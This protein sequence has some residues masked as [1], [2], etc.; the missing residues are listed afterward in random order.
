MATSSLFVKKGLAQIKEIED[1][2]PHILGDRDRLIQVV[3]NLISNA[4]KFTDEGSVTCCARQIK[5]ELVISII[6]TGGYVSNSDDVFEEEIRKQV[7][8]AIDEADVVIFLVDVL[9]GI[10][11]LDQ[12][13][14]GML[15]KINKPVLLVVNK[16]DNL[17]QLLN[18]L[19][20]FSI[21]ALSSSS[22]LYL[23]QITTKSA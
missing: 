10:T 12:T 16:V 21:M 7:L 11:D 20:I 14:A 13:I 19:N 3:I 2:L 8:L 15:R 18:V 17:F 5:N 1:N 4:V 22:I 6:D 9:S 23:Q